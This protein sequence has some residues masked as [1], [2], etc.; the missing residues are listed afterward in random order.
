MGY[1]AL[2]FRAV[3]KRQVL[4]V[5][6]DDD[7]GTECIYNTDTKKFR[8]LRHVV[9]WTSGEAPKHIHDLQVELQDAVE[10]S[11]SCVLDLGYVSVR[12]FFSD[13]KFA[14]QD[15]SPLPSILAYDA[16]FY[17]SVDDARG[18]RCAPA[19][20]IEMPD[21][22]RSRCRKVISTM[23]AIKRR[24]NY[25]A[26][27]PFDMTAYGQRLD[28]LR[29][30]FEPCDPPKSD[31]LKLIP[32]SLSLDELSV[33][34]PELEETNKNNGLEP[35]PEKATASKSDATVTLPDVFKKYDLPPGFNKTAVRKLSAARVRQLVHDIKAVDSEF[36][37]KYIESIHSKSGVPTKQD[38]IAAVMKIKDS[39]N[40][41][42]SI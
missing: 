29:E 38:L 31:T 32:F 26:E 39:P 19:Y 4:F 24:T 17:R 23:K 36:E 25:D 5:V 27:A 42:N 35:R 6:V 12:G 11:P 37:T 40:K 16:D 30:S 14:D 13:Q 18:Y 3:N 9:G 21:E 28:M 41:S 33:E 20:Y 15:I 2:L 22:F 7:C 8:V 1:D 34:T 10:D